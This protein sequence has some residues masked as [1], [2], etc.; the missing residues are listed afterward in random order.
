[1]TDHKA[2]AEGWM[3]YSGNLSS[4]ATLQQVAHVT[5]MAQVHA[6][7]YSAEQQEKIAEQLRVG[8]LIALARSVGDPA[9][10]ATPAALEA[11]AAISEDSDPYG[12][13]PEIR[14]V[15]GL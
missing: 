9:A 1:M 14:K 10:P 12:I 15:L 6:T 11:D 7:L 5:G 3:N 8:N 4:E 13:R 2:E